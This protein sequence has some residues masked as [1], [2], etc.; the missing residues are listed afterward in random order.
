[1]RGGGVRGAG[2]G[3]GHAIDC[4]MRV[5]AWPIGCAKSPIALR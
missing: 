1:V 4:R 3:F 2:A 5:V